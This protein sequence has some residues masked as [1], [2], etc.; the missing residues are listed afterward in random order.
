MYLTARSKKIP[1]EA[2]AL[3]LRLAKSKNYFHSTFIFRQKIEDREKIEK[4]PKICLFIF[5]H[6]SVALFLTRHRRSLCRA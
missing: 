1:M 3:C 2:E 4:D 6:K 5:F